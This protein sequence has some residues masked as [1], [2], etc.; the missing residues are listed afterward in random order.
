MGQMGH[1]S[2]GSWVSSLMAQMGHGSRG[3]W[4]SSL[5]GQLGHGSQNVSHSRLWLC[6]I[7]CKKLTLRRC[8]I[9]SIRR[10]LLRPNSTQLHDITGLL[11]NLQSYVTK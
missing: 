9:L 6:A 1:G 8:E 4:V 10:H 5:M 2:R 11:P 3:S 7:R